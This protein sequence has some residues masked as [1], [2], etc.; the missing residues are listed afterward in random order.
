MKTYQI[1]LYLIKGTHAY[2][3]IISSETK[4]EIFNL[5]PKTIRMAIRKKKI[6]FCV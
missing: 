1:L 4:E 3:M 6:S 2:H 5:K